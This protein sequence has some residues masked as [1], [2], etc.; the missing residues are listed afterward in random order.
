MGLSIGL[1]WPR[2]MLRPFTRHRVAS[3]IRT[4]L[5]PCIV[6]RKWSF[7]SY[8]AQYIRATKRKSK[9]WDREKTDGNRVRDTRAFGEARLR[10]LS[11]E[12]RTRHWKKEIPF[13]VTKENCLKDWK[14][15][16][17]Y[18]W[19]GWKSRELQHWNFWFTILCFGMVFIYTYLNDEDVSLF[20][21]RS[22]KTN[23]RIIM[24]H[25]ADKI[26]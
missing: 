26:Y 19:W 8:I 2:L 21:H 23:W 4:N 10:T 17:S 9:N 11:C 1:L 24:S 25:K 7:C 13:V 5:V 12:I 3:R 22:K 15:I 14:R 20:I 18:V 16:F 6:N